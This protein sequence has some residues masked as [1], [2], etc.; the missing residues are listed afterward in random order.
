MNPKAM[1]MLEPDE[2]FALISTRRS[3]RHFTNE[4]LPPGTTTSLLEAMVLAPNGGNAQAWHFVCVE[5]AQLRQDLAT[6][7]LSQSFIAAAPLVIVVCVDLP[8]AARAYGQ[9]GV[10]LY[11]LQDTA[12]AIQN[13]LLMAHGMGLGGCWVGAFRERSVAQLLELPEHLRPVALVAVGVPAEQPPMPTR[14]ELAEVSE[15]R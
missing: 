8:R 2:V 7:A 15:R 11:C 14:R 12:A 1:A 10:A 13:L 3:I 4:P 5:S 6:A 9:R